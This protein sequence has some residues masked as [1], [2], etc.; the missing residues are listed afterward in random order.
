LP[1]T[2]YIVRDGR[3]A[4]VSFYHY[5]VTRAGRRIPF[6]EWFDLYCKRWYG[7][8]WRDHVE[9]W[10]DDGRKHLRDDL[11]VVRFEELKASTMA[12]VQTVAEFLGLPT[13]ID[14]IS[15]SVDMAGLER[16]REREKRDFGRLQNPNQSFYRGGKTGQWCDYLVDETY[17]RFMDMSAQALKLAGYLE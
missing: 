7:P 1:R 17:D 16:A 15:R 5:T 6:P 4:L 3:D 12:R 2:V 10:L 14:A 13:D 8:R 11:L 9:S